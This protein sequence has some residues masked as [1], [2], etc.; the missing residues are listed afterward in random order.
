MTLYLA[1]GAINDWLFERNIPSFTLEMRG[2]GREELT[3]FVIEEGEIE[4]AA[5]ESCYAMMQLVAALADGFRPTKCAEASKYHDLED[6]SRG[7][8]LST[9]NI[10]IIAVVAGVFGLALIATV[11]YIALR[12]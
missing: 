7:D 2:G 1:N 6:R 4:P 8:G 10:I 3:G 11:L 9:T 5:F 12:K